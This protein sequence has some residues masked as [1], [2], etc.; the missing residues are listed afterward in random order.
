MP[1]AGGHWN[2]TDPVTTRVPLR[3]RL[4]VGALTTVVA[5]AGSTVLPGIAAEHTVA[6][7]DVLSTIADEHAVPVDTLIE[8][9]D[10]TD[11]DLIYIGQVI[12]LPGSDAPEPAETAA[13]HTVEAGDTMWAIARLHQLTVDALAALNA[14]DN[15]A[16]ITIGQVLDLPGDGAQSSPPP[17]DDQTGLT[18]LDAEEAG[19][20][21][22]DVVVH[23]VEPGDTLSGIAQRYGVELD[24]LLA[25]NGLTRSSVI[26][27]GQR[28]V[29]SATLAEID[30]ADLADLPQDLLTD[31]DRLSLLP[32]F[33]R[34][35]AHYGV[36]ADLVKA[37]AWF[38]SGWNN[39]VVSSAGA[40]GIGQVLPITADFV[41]DVL[42]GEELDPGIP[43][44]NIRLSIRY[45][46][47]LLDETDDVRL[48]IASYYQ[49]LTATRRHGIYTS[50]QFY[51][52]GILALRSRFD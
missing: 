26:V 30:P 32:V 52:D 31:P 2:M 5:A 34:W 36:P 16:L 8:L 11:P 41:S 12:D 44:E 39:E 21:P 35:A 49:G 20:A 27:P 6:P 23:E 38:E 13:T 37:L 9:N 46:R 48:A 14:I 22:D 40:L 28:I 24:A 19:P 7:G 25:G 42:L 15:P 29:I 18:E 43:E 45:L 10:L 47:Y 4:A 3:R 1:L 17:A 33:D 51:V 50:S